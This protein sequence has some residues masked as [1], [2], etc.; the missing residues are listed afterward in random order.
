MWHPHPFPEAHDM[1]EDKAREVG[2]LIGQSDEYKA[3][4]RSSDALSADPQAANALR[5]MESIRQAAQQMI[6]RGEQPGADMEQE[7]DT[8]LEQVQVNDAYQRAVV[9][10]DNFDKL[11]LRVNQW[12]ADGIKAGAASPIITLG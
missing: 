6:D 5:R 1:L 3:V 10:Q 4:K 9:A 11:M 12:I 2:R 8:L 7:L